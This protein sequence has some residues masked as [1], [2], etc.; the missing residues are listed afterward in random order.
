MKRLM[1][2]VTILAAL[3]VMAAWSVQALA[4]E[5]DPVFGYQLVNITMDDIAADETLAEA[6]Y[7]NCPVWSPDGSTIAFI[8]S[9][10][11]IYVVSSQGGLP[12]RIWEPDYR[13]EYED[14]PFCRNPQ[15][16]V[17]HPFP[18]LMILLPYD[19]YSFHVS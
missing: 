17:N 10:Q 7:Q 15:L 9:W 16:Q 13:Y 14:V 2:V 1:N 3:A 6:N 11:C 4:A 5:V 8:G 18:K 19:L 12:R